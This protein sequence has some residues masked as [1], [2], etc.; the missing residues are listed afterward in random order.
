MTITIWWR[1]RLN[2]GEPLHST[3]GMLP[4][5][6]TRFRSGQ[7]PNGWPHAVAKQSLYEDYRA[8]HY[9]QYCKPFRETPYYQDHPEKVPVP[10]ERHVFF[11]VMA[12][13]IQPTGL[14]S[15]TYPIK[16][17]TIHEGRYVRVKKS[18]SFYR[19]ASLEE[20]QVAFRLHTGM[21]LGVTIAPYDAREVALLAAEQK[22]LG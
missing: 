13:L 18:Q 9:S 11:S 15:K 16:V 21:S 6:H 2:K 5:V 1:E 19:L 4:G 17:G 20:H 8:W 22:R 14:A 10:A 7:G 12:P 3:E